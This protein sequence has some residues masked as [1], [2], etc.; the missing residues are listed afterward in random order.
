MAITTGG[1]SRMSTEPTGQS[2]EAYWKQ[3][4]EFLRVESLVWALDADALMRSF[5]IVAQQAERDLDE[6]VQRAVREAA[7]DDGKSATSPSVR[8]YVP[9]VG[10]NAMMLGA[11]ATE[12]LLKGIAVSLPAVRT[13]IQSNDKSVARRLW[14]HNLQDIAQLS[15]I[16][17][18]LQE[19]TLC[20]RL[21]CFLQWAGRYSTP[22]DPSQMMPR[23]LAS[24]GTA[25]PNIYSSA[26]FNAIRAL[27]RRLRAL[28]PQIDSPQA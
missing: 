28:L 6:V 10:P 5:D 27:V 8:P 11:L 17:L 26:N 15:G 22:K 13:A 19:K 18:A 12:T 2:K 7:G 1:G 21:E 25:P 4:F 20:E 3:Q 23:P 24:G 9:S 14:T 16:T